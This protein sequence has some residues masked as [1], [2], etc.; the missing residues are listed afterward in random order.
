MFKPAVGR[1]FKPGVDGMFKPVVYGSADQLPDISLL[2]YYISPYV[3]LR[4]PNIFQIFSPI[5]LDISSRFSKF[6]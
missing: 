1:M 6:L 2:F 4:F 3:F 5:P